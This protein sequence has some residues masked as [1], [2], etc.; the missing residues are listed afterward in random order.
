MRTN[1][2]LADNMKRLLALGLFSGMLPCASFLAHA[3]AP[4]IPTDSGNQEKIVEQRPDQNATEG[5]HDPSGES[6]S[7]SPTK[8]NAKS[9]L[10]YPMINASYVGGTIPGMPLLLKKSR[11]ILW[12]RAYQFRLNGKLAM[13]PCNMVFAF[14]SKQTISGKGALQVYTCFLSNS[15]QPNP[16]LSRESV[17]L[18]HQLKQDS[19]V[20]GLQKTWNVM[21]IPYSEINV[22]SRDRKLSAD[23]A[24]NKTA[25]VT[26]AIALLTSILSISNKT[27]VKLLYGGVT[28][29]S[30]VLV[31]CYFVQRPDG[32]ENYIAIF[33]KKVDRGCASEKLTFPGCN[34]SST[35]LFQ[36]GDLAMFRISNFH[37]YYNIS[38]ILS[39]ETG[40]QFVPESA[41][42]GAT[43]P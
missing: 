31:Y 8:C 16:L 35:D 37:D 14:D 19:D 9:D 26:A 30:A 2:T 33:T 28:I 17:S 21:E 38:M 32:Q 34:A 40:L 4:P 6:P 12:L 39:G 24:A 11:G 13:G 41:D 22:L 36:P 42:K 7:Q 43:K 27:H 18:C 20:A 29:G 23:Q 3:Q 5:Q 1:I 25:Y 15:D 10:V